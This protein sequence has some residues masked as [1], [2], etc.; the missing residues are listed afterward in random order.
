V[1]FLACLS[2]SGCG[3]NDPRNEGLTAGTFE[4]VALETPPNSDGSA[5]AASDAGPLGL[6]PCKDLPDKAAIEKI[7]GVSLSDPVELPVGC[8]L[9][10]TANTSDVVT[11]TRQTV[12]EKNA[13]LKYRAD[14]G[15]DPPTDL[16]DPALPNA[17]VAVSYSVL[18]DKGDTNY[19]TQVVVGNGPAGSGLPM[20]T[21]LMKLWAGQ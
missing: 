17:V 16:G 11:F 8:E 12:Q 3:G 7:M 10:G 19:M 6:G 15:G 14:T 20:A 13:L 1:A 9:R 18:Y 2:L 5:T 21:E 4:T